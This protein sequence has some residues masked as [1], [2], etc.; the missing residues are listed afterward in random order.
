MIQHGIS[1]EDKDKEDAARQI[2]V[3]LH[4]KHDR[5]RG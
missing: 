2:L 5:Q 3:P 4:E 1:W